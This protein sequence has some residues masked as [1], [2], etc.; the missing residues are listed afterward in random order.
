MIEAAST[1]SGAVWRLTSENIPWIL[2]RSSHPHENSHSSI[3]GP[4]ATFVE[5]K[6]SAEQTISR[7]VPGRRTTR[8]RR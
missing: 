3:S 6:I 7:F 8:Q 2:I 1:S 5:W 4:F